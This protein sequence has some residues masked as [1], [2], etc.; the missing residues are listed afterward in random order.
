LVDLLNDESSVDLLEVLE[1]LGA[2]YL[3]EVENK[4]NL[5]GAR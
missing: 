5:R 3:K 4:P 1:V 2:K